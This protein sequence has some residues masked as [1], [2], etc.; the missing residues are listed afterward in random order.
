MD[1]IFKE[2]REVAM[3][4]LSEIAHHGITFEFRIF[5]HSLLDSFW[6]IQ[7]VFRSHFAPK[8]IYSSIYAEALADKL[9]SS[10]AFKLEKE[11]N[12]ILDDLLIDLL[13]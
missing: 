11:R 12:Y 13:C 4:F 1:Y 6:C 9:S 3:D 8:E 2:C 7:V 5:K 10:L